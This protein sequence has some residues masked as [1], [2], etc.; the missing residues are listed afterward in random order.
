MSID[1]TLSGGGA[2][3]GA[4]SS[5][6][7]Y[8]VTEESTPVILSD[9]TGGIGQVS[10]EA[11]DDTS[12]FGSYLMVSSDLTL[13]D[14]MR[15]TAFGT[16]TNMSGNNGTVSVS[17]DSKLIRLVARRNAN[18]VNGTFGAAVTYYLSLVGITT[19]FTIDASLT[20]KSVVAPGWEQQDVWTK[21]KELCVLNGAEIVPVGNNIAIRPVRTIEATPNLNS[22]YPNWS[23]TTG[24]LSQTVKINYYNNQYRTNFLVEPEG[25]WTPEARVLQVEAGETV[26]ENIPVNM[27]VT[28]VQQPTVMNSV[29]RGHT[30]SSAYSV[31][32][33]DGFP[34]PAQQW[35][36]HGGKITFAIGEDKQSIDVTMKGPKTTSATAKYGPFR[37]AVSSGGSEY[38]S[39]LRVC[40][41]GV[42]FKEEELVVPT[43]I[44]P[45]RGTEE[46]ITVSSQFVRDIK[47]A[48]AVAMGVTR[49]ANSTNRTVTFRQSVFKTSNPVPQTFGYVAGARVRWRRAVYRVRSASITD[50][51]VEFTAE[52]DTTFSDFQASAT[53]MTFNNFAA[54]YAGI[55]FE[56]FSL[57][58][59]PVVKAEYDR[60]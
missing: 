27:W 31:A 21:L 3:D 46:G 28:A 13:S 37:L 2:F 43:G 32:G 45:G 47:E 5:I 51:V 24:E 11:V 30:S 49:M 9:T 17:G 41:T 12:R 29:P 1:V 18:S 57:I 33:N 23:V 53:G 40:A 6:F 34:I 25:G 26:T 7:S 19:G 39:T 58:P 60:N 16:I 59:L 15:G 36:D 22:E 4:A 54:S 10:F 56:E 55:T 48:H 14:D 52:A 50:S 44:E 35:T 38:Y 20:S 8:S 42:Y